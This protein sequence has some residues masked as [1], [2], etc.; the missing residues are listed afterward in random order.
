MTRRTALLALLL[1]LAWTPGTGPCRP[2]TPLGETAWLALLA[3]QS[4]LAQTSTAPWTLTKTG[5]LDPATAT[6]TW[7]VVASP[8]GSATR[9]LVVTIRVTLVNLGSAPAPVGSVVVRLQTRTRHGWW[10][11][12]SSDVADATLG[13][14]ATT[15]WIVDGLR[16]RQVYEDAASGA[17]AI[18]GV[19]DATPLPLV[20]PLTVPAQAARRVEV[21]A[22]FDNDVLGLPEGTEVRPELVVTFG[23]ALPGLRSEARLD[24]DGD[25]AI[26][27]TEGRVRS[28]LQRFAAR[29]VPAP[30][31]SEVVLT[32]T[33]SDIT[34][35]G[36]VTVSAP[37]F[38]LGP[39]GGTVQAAYDPG[40]AGGTITNCAHLTG[41]AADLEACDTQTVPAPGFA[42]QDGDLVT[43]SQVG[44][45][46]APGST[47]LGTGLTQVYPSG[48][49]EVGIPGA[50][51]FSM[52]FTSASQILGYLPEIGPSGRLTADLLNP[53]ATPGGTFA[54]D[55][56]ALQLTLDYSDAG[57]LGGALGI[58]F[59]NLTLCGLP[60]LPLLEGMSVRELVA[61][62]N[63]L[64]GGG[65]GTYTINQSLAIASNLSRA[66]DGGVVS[67]FARDHLVIG[68][69]PA[70]GWQ[71]GDV[72]TY[73]QDTW[74]EVPTPTN[75]AGLLFVNF[76]AV[77][78]SRGGLLEIGIPGATGFS[79]RFHNASSLLSFLPQ[80]GAPGPLTG[81]LLGPTTSPAGSF[82]GAV[83][84]LAV[85]VD[86]S[87]AGLTL[88]ARGVP[89][90][91]LVLCGLPAQPL[92]EG[93]T[94]REV[95]AEANIAL[96]GGIAVYSL[97]EMSI[98]AT[99]LSNAFDGGVVGSYAQHLAI[100]S[101][102]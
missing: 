56:L 41:G 97:N 27:P 76:D 25:G 68:A 91:D 85:N 34:T 62:L 78:V 30:I 87:D 61:E 15:A 86:F 17:L 73:G 49:V 72:I 8:S 11:T 96:G 80:A 66:F 45:T 94:V 22:T 55:V 93:M 65:A 90:G 32:D 44:W 92:L 102:P 38:Q 64:L 75:P 36:S 19:P 4:G 59:G 14:A 84:A 35:T 51:G 18:L 13:D 77:Y 20:A 82:G 101:C 88:G 37:V 98:L 12:V 21:T 3:P 53:T 48:L 16:A 7:D 42:W 99:V 31:P 81:D 28:E 46:Q 33:A 70:A 95:L 67:P 40:P 2:P 5:V 57:R 23:N 52:L 60:T 74:G 50:A 9:A 58:P 89:F 6:V 79:A 63:V 43:Y 100:G 10:S 54:A 26:G 71:D 24:I 29:G 69:C 39:D 1:T 47:V 83:A